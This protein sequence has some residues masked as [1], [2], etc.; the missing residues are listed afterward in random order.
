[1][2]GIEPLLKLAAKLVFSTTTGE[3]FT[4]MQEEK[5]FGCGFSD[6]GGWGFKK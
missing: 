6:F 3:T 4:P 1:M 5:N 2:A